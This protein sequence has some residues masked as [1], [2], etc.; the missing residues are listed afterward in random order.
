MKFG[1]K[2]KGKFVVSR[3]SVKRFSGE[4]FLRQALIEQVIDEAMREELLVAPFGES[5]LVVSEPLAAN[6]RKVPKRLVTELVEE[7]GENA[8][9]GEE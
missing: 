6:Y 3:V 9:D 8:G 2:L 1:G 5:F 4:G 7:D